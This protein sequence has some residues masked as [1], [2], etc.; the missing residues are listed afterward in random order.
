M[1]GGGSAWRESKE[2]KEHGSAAVGDERLTSYMHWAGKD[3][4]EVGIEKAASVKS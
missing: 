1:S 3:W 4:L 2:D